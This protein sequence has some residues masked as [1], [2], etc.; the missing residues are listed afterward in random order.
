MTI[1]QRIQNIARKLYRPYEWIFWSAT[2]PEYIVKTLTGNWYID[3]T[4]AIA[5]SLQYV[6]LFWWID[7]RN[8]PEWYTELNW[9]IGD[10]SAYLDL[11][12]TLD[13]DDQIEIEFTAKYWSWTQIFWYRSAA[14]SQNVTLFSGSS[15]NSIFED[16]NNS[17]YAPYRMSGTLTDWNKYFAIISKTERKIINESW[18]TVAINSTSC[19]D[20]ITTWNVYLFFA[21][22][23]P[24]WTWKFQWTIHKCVIKW[25]RNLIPCKNSSN[26][27]WMYDTINGVFYSNANETWNFV[28]WSDAIPTPTKPIDII[29]NNW[30]I[31][32]TRNMADVN[33]QTALIGYYI[34]N[35]GVLTSDTNNRIYQDY[36]SVLPNTTYTLSFDTNV[37]YVTIS[38]YS[39]QDDSGF[40]KRNAGTS[41]TNT[42]LTITTDANTNYVR[43]GTNIDRSVVTMER[44][45]EINRQLE[46]WSTITPYRPYS[47]T[48]Y[49][50]MW[51]T[52]TVE[53][54]L[55]NTATAKMLLWIWNTKDVQEVL[56]WH[57]TRYIWIKVFDGTE[58]WKNISSYYNIAKTDLNTSSTVLPAASIDIIC[59]HY[60]TISGVPNRTSVNV[61]GSY[62]NFRDDNIST[63]ADWKQW[64]INQ[65]NAWTPVIIVYPLAEPTTETVTWQTLNIQNGTNRIEITQA[66]ISN[67]PLEIQ[68]HATS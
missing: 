67:L 68:F 5:N 6:K 11:N 47:S 20:T 13:Q 63:L 30:T 64:L 16:F 22:W 39:T 21:G 38:E 43:F 32:Y 52:E 56:T 54:S 8:L 50:V 2:P 34:S 66:S 36:I 45:L 29:C 27:L 33:D 40:I 41:W 17:D 12:C 19:P 31:K 26:V 46:E 3:L 1:N 58:D 55:N 10:W 44:V 65:Y 57:V 28:A 24:S 53:D 61:G 35:T 60:E 23:S 59:T 42:S 15:S 37:Y 48:W 62:I 51:T 4:N 7:Q 25:K 49:C 14:S 9:L 18:T